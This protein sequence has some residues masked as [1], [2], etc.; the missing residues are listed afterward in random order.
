VTAHTFTED[1]AYDV[2][3][4]VDDGHG[5]T[6]TATVKIIVG[7]PPDLLV[8]GDFSEGLNGWR[9]WTQRGGFDPPLVSNGQLHLRSSNHNGGVYQQ[10]DTGG[11]GTEI[12]I[13]GSWT[14]DPTHP[15]NQWAEVLIINSDRPDRQPVNGRDIHDGLPD[16]VLIYKNDT[17]DEDTR[18]GW[19]GP[20]SATAV[21]NNTGSFVA[22]SDKATIVLKS[23]NVG[24]VVTG[25][26]F[27][28]IVVT[29]EGVPPIPDNRDPEAVAKATPV[30]G[31][32]PLAVSFD[33]SGSSDPDGD[34]LT[35][36]WDFGDGQ[37]GA[38]LTVSHTYTSSGTF[39]AVLTVNDGNGGVD[40]DTVFVTVGQSTGSGKSKLTIHT[41]FLGPESW[42]FLEQAQPTVVKILDELKPEVTQGVKDRSP[43]TLIVGRIWYD[44]RQHLGDGSPEVRAQEWWDNVKETLLKNPAVDYWE[45]YNEPVIHHAD[46]MDWYARFERNGDAPC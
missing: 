24:G 12:T 21:V 16:V 39:R 20:M 28:D 14:G 38:G 17:W 19:D 7:S 4:T 40:T 46:L 3:L 6:D 1:G 33:A 35:Y 41:S 10:F 13:D 22:A 8:N 26:R 5:G 32:P 15:D 23:G 36:T 43:N 2:V 45:G 27:D 44:D 31:E 30:A 25:T 29:V 42:W 18:D 9:V 37:Q 34:D 11:E